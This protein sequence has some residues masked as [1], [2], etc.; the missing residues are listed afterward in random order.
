MLKLEHLTKRYGSLCA[1]DDLSLHLK[2]G[3]LYGFLGPNGAGKTTTMKMIAG[4][5]EP[6]AGKIIID[7]LDLAR[8]TLKAKS[9][10]GYVPDRPYLYDRLTALEYLDFVA[11]LYDMPK[12]HAREQAL[13]WLEIFELLPRK[14]ALCES[15]S[16][17]MKQRLVLASVLLHRPRLL[18]VDEPMVGL[19]PKGAKLLKDLLRRETREFG[20]TVIFSTHTLEVANELCDALAVIDHGKIIA[21]GSPAELRAMGGEGQSLEEIFLKLTAEQSNAEPENPENQKAR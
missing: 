7:G 11:S 2:P 21:Q 6:T 1:V 17:G 14:D 19:D 4:L 20:T 18:V 10:L 8:D 16:H 12:K 3:E 15:F 5:I 13:A 9:R